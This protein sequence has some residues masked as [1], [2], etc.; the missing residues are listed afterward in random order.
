MAF[1][2]SLHIASSRRSPSLLRQLT[3]LADLRR[4]RRA[5]RNL[6][7]HRLEDIG[8]TAREADREAA[9]PVWDAPGNWRI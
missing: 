7:Q 4:Q 6:D 3:V 2:Q 5:L 9:R 8:V 1:S